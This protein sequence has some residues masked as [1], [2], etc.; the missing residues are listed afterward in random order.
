MLS[1]G[2]AG[3]SF[4]C[5]NNVFIK[6]R[7]AFKLAFQNGDIFVAL[8]SFKHFEMKE[9]NVALEYNISP[10]DSPVKPSCMPLPTFFH[11]H[12][13]FPLI[14]VVCICI[15][16]DDLCSLYSCWNLCFQGWLLG[17]GQ[18]V[19]AI[20]PGE[21]HLSSQS[22]SVLCG[23]LCRVVTS[24]AFLSQL[25]MCVDVTIVQPMFRQSHL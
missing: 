22:S 21:E 10:F 1:L 14:A 11:T 25:G 18:T 3:G 20:F 12:N 17:I 6:T 5:Q 13:V 23:S 19:D 8:F 9:N 4:Q 16:K 15:S 7:L 24:W 2:G